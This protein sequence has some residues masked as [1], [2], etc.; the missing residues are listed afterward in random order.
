MF[1]LIGNV[2]LN[3]STSVGA[4]RK[5]RVAFLPRKSSQADLLMDPN[6]RCFFQ[7]AQDVGQAMGGLQADKKMDMIGDTADSLR[8]PTETGKLRSQTPGPTP[9]PPPRTGARAP[10]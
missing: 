6:G 10:A 9:A 7:L 5:R 1:L 8:Q 4:D 3:R 2:P